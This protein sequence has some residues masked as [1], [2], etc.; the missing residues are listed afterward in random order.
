VLYFSSAPALESDE[1]AFENVG[2]LFGAICQLDIHSGHLLTAC[3]AHKR[4][5]ESKVVSGFE[6]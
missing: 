2:Q 6:R 4:A 1:H 5:Q 3:T